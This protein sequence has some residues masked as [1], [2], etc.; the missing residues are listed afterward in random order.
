M[1]VQSLRNRAGSREGFEV[2]GIVRNPKYPEADSENAGAG[3]SLKC[4]GV[5]NR[6]FQ[7]G[8]MQ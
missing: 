5:E 3:E 7:L 6:V 8:W 1:Q 4:C 2:K